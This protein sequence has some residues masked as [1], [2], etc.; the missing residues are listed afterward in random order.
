MD[1]RYKNYEQYY[2]AANLDTDAGNA[3]VRTSESISEDSLGEKAP[4][5]FGPDPEAGKSPGTT[6]ASSRG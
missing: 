5:Q 1:G 6:V 3:S 2:Q 4:D